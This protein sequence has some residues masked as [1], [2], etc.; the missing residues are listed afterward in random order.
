MTAAGKAAGAGC[1]GKLI[2]TALLGGFRA[3]GSPCSLQAQ[4]Q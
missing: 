3:F 2:E 1:R 4:V